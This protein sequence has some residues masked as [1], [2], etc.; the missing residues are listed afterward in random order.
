MQSGPL[1]PGPCAIVEHEK[2]LSLLACCPA[3]VTAKNAKGCERLLLRGV[4]G[5]VQPGNML[6]SGCLTACGAMLF[7]GMGAV[8]EQV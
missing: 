8:D 5:Y 1:P 2:M 7:G 3:Q 4:D 6:V